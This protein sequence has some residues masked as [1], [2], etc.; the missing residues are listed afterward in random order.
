MERAHHDRA[1]NPRRRRGA[2]G[3]AGVTDLVLAPEHAGAL[4]AKRSSSDARNGS[5]RWWMRRYPARRASRATRVSHAHGSRSTAGESARS[6]VRSGSDG[7][8]QNSGTRGVHRGTMASPRRR[9]RR[10]TSRARSP[11]VPVLNATASSCASSSR[12]TGTVSSMAKLQMSASLEVQRRNCEVGASREACE[13]FEVTD[14]R[15]KDGHAATLGHPVGN[16]HDES[17]GDA[18]AVAAVWVRLRPETSGM[19]VV[20][21]RRHRPPP[22]GTTGVVKRL[23][24]PIDICVGRSSGLGLDKNKL[25]YP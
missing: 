24:E 21:P 17:V 16:C 23:Q 13:Q 1:A 18:N 22:V 7:I 5:V 11:S 8:S 20:V 10:P 6:W 25:R 15:R 14:I 2:R 9:P 4:V 12:V 19:V 3:G